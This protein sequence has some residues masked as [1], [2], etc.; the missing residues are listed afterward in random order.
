MNDFWVDIGDLSLMSYSII[1]R[2]NDYQ[3]LIYIDALILEAGHLAEHIRPSGV[4]VSVRRVSMSGGARGVWGSRG[5]RG[6]GVAGRHRAHGDRCGARRS[7]VAFLSFAC[8]PSSGDLPQTAYEVSQILVD[9]SRIT[10]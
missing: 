1:S 6:G 8:P 2:L 9:V 4:C 10:D 7:L 3:F 5:A